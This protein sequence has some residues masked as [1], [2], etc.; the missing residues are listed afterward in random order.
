MK[1]SKNVPTR[2]ST[3][4]FLALLV[5][6]FVAA[7]FLDQA[8]ERG[9]LWSVA[10]TVVLLS[11]GFAVGDRRVTRLW[12]LLGASPA[13]VAMWLHHLFPAAV[14][15]R[16]SHVF[17]W[18][19]AVWVSIRL[20]LFVLR[21]RQVDGEVLAAAAATYLMA[22]LA[23]G[24]AYIVAYDLDPKAF[25]F[26]AGPQAGQPIKG[27]TALYFSL[28]T[29]STVAYGDIMPASPAARLMAMA[30]AV[31]GIFYM[32]IVVARLVSTYSG[33]HSGKEP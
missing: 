10:L 19:F 14:P 23:W 18:V 15:M 1:I 31:A 17:F 20:F 28:S 3:R 13:I 2:Y 12:V 26:A 33:Q 27:F 24:T 6:V 5:A 7:P 8:G 16:I 30:E 21:A 4:E 25:S 11:S 9:I 22:A 32:T 29:L